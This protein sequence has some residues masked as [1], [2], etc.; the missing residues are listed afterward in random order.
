MD[1]AFNA[2]YKLK[3]IPEQSFKLLLFAESKCKTFGKISSEDLKRIYLKNGGRNFE[4]NLS[5]LLSNKFIA[6]A[7]REKKFLRLT[8]SGCDLLALSSLS[9]K[10]SITSFGP[11]IARGKESDVY[12][13]GQDQ[14]QYIIKFYRI[15]RI[16]FR[17]V[18][19]KRSYITISPNWF[20]R[21]IKAAR[22]E[23]SAYKI[24]Q[25]SDARIPKLFLRNRHALVLEFIKGQRLNELSK[26]EITQDL[27]FKIVDQ[28]KIM[29]AHG[30]VHVDLSP[31]NVLVDENY[32][33][34]IIDFP[35]WVPVNHPTALEYIRRD[36][37]NL[38]TFFK[39]KK[40]PIDEEKVINEVLSSIKISKR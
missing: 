10:L 3:D 17:D 38:I 25:N 22:A 39:R 20:L 23:E 13:L 6:W 26:E 12:I 34:Y 4:V 21:S 9:K 33:V 5:F 15:G 40:V 18:K 28:V 14:S 27:L 24:L 31:F 8:F 1:D 2:W 32:D 11:C 35:Q 19:R 36:L 16:S 29:I 30:I 37:G 7:D